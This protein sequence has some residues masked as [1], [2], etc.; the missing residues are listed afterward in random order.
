MLNTSTEL[1]GDNN[2]W[3]CVH[4]EI[5]RQMLYSDAVT[6]TTYAQLLGPCHNCSLMDCSSTVY[7]N[8]CHSELPMDQ[9]SDMLTDNM[10][11]RLKYDMENALLRLS[12]LSSA[13]EVRPHRVRTQA[14]STFQTQHFT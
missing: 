10:A 1:F 2:H 7:C 8:F 13:A 3:L 9:C 12:D 5:H 14:T 11:R 4:C 6:A